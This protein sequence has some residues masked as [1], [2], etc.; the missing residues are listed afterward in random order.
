[1]FKSRNFDFKLNKSMEMEK[2]IGVLKV[3]EVEE[4]SKRLR[5]EE[6]MRE[7]INEKEKEL[8]ASK[9]KFLEIETKSINRFCSHTA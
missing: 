9:D 6:E 8:C 5:I 1:M 3:K 2:K 7:T 4:R